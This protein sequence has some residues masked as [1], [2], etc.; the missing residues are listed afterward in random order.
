MGI[1]GAISPNRT[2]GSGQ[3]EETTTLV[4][5]ATVSATAA[6]SAWHEAGSGLLPG[7]GLS[8][9]ISTSMRMPS[10]ASITAVRSAT[11]AGR[12]LLFVWPMT[13]P[14]AS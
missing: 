13:S 5:L 6:A 8:I 3:N 14:F 7:S 4:F 9:L 2:S 12:S 1:L 10:Q 11:N